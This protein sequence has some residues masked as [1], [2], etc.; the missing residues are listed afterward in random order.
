MLS[1]AGARNPRAG[2]LER[3]ALLG[4]EMLRVGKVHPNPARTL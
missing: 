3:G 4:D 1:R 2:T